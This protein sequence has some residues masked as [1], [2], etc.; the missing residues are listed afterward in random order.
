MSKRLTIEYERALDAL[1]AIADMKIDES[2][3][4]AELSALMIAIART[5]IGKTD[6]DLAK[7]SE[8]TITGIIR[9]GR[10]SYRIMI[11]SVQVGVILR[12][13]PREWRVADF[14][15]NKLMTTTSRGLAG[16]WALGKIELEGR[17][18][19]WI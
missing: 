16:S 3:N 12:L 14:Y 4:H 15:G 19:P 7:K 17:K 2:T 18:A 11:K 13:G 9:V 5:A 6:K 10:I 1:R 8:T